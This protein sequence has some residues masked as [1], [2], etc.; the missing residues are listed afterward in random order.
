IRTFITNYPPQ[1]A[2]GAGGW[3]ISPKSF[4]TNRWESNLRNLQTCKTNRRERYEQ[5]H[6]PNRV[7]SQCRQTSGGYCRSGSGAYRD[8]SPRAQEILRCAP[9]F[10]RT[11][12]PRSSVGLPDQGGDAAVPRWQDTSPV[13]R[14]RYPRRLATPVGNCAPV[15]MLW[16]SA[17]A[18]SLTRWS[19]RSLVDHLYRPGVYG[20]RAPSPAIPGIHS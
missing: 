18:G 8:V 5:T 1:S 12:C 11:G 4:Q 16:L 10:E 3:V 14:C 15:S 20:R 19:G 7:A 9:T 13:L 17:A 2:W 6:L